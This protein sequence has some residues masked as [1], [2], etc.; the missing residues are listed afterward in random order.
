LQERGLSFDRLVVRMGNLGPN[1]GI[2]AAIRSVPEW[3]G[4]WGLVLLG[5]PHGTFLQ[6]MEQLVAGLGLA[7]RV[8][9]LTSPS[10]CLWYSSQ[11]L[12][13]DLLYSADLGLALYEPGNINHSYMVGPGNKMMLCLKAGIPTLMSDLPDFADFIER[14]PV[15]VLA[16]PTDPHSIACSINT[17]F[18][19]DARYA[20]LSRNA[21]RLFETEFNFEVQFEP[22]LRWIACATTD[23][24]R[25]TTA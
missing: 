17:L 24:G 23:D 11:S 7:D 2:E 10:E 16:N 18:S 4:N 6:E 8:V 1:H 12:W 15:G 22:V 9:F 13:Y 3:K 21:R 25:Q 20:E 19:D 5:L 14:H